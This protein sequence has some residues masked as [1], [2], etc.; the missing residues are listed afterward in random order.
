M[1]LGCAVASES[2]ASAAPSVER[3]RE[4]DAEMLVQLARVRDAQLSPDGKRIAYVVSKPRPFDDPGTAR[5]EIRLIPRQGGE[6]RT[7]TAPGLSSSTPRWSPDGRHLA[8]LS[9]RKD[10][11]EHRQVF[12]LP[13]DGGEARAVTHSPSGV[14]SFEWSPDGT[15][16]AYLARRELDADEQA[17]HDAG[18]DWVLDDASGTAKQL[19]VVDVA[20]ENERSVSQGTRAISSFRWAPDGKRFLVRAA[21]D[22]SVDSGMMYSSLYT[23]DAAGGEMKK[24]CDTEG[25]LGAMAW[26]PD[27][28]QVAFLG[29]LDIHDSTSSNVYVAPSTGGNARLLIENYEGSA[30]WVGWQDSSS[31]LFLA[32][33]S[34]ETVLRRI[35]AAGGASKKLIGHAPTCHGLAMAKDRKTFACAGSRPSHPAEA[36]T[37]SLGSRDLRRVTTVNP[38]LEEARLGRQEVVSWKAGD[39]LELEGI[40]IK[41]V[42]Y[43][44][45]TRYPLAVLPHGGPE[46]VSLH[47][48]GSGANYPAQLFA[49][50]GYVVFMPNYRGSSGRGSKFAVLDHKDLGG[51]EFEDVMAG[52]DHLASVGM[53]DPEQVG[54]GGWSYGG[55]FSGLASTKWSSRFK[56]T[57]VAASISNWMSFTG[58]TEIEHENSLVHWNLWPYDEPELVWERSPMA[59]IEGSKTATLVVHGSA[60]SRVPPSQSRELYRALRHAGAPTQLVMYPREPHGLIENVHQLDFVERWLG[61]FDLHVKGQAPSKAPSKAPGKAPGKNSEGAG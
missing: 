52:I 8:F 37:G 15:A 18:R 47:G 36:F 48:W 20:G 40:I 50:R 61:W 26:S 4:L 38:G 29:A 19:W 55:Y 23:L 16:I 17:Q 51:A 31:I 6:S 57:M 7:L 60:D 41:P 44:E 45:G 32:N 1:L 56:A 12:L 42:G 54:M 21:D 30:Q 14:S 11:D 53:I 43:I 24:L 46:G 13:I 25:K 2:A 28:K 3:T 35:P 27:G 10:Q 5:S 39:G 58:T 34:T 33:E 9:T 22:P 59:H 49:S